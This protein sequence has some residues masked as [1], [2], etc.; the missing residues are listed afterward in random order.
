MKV[1]KSRRYLV[2][3][4]NVHRNKVLRNWKSR[5]SVDTKF[6]RAGPSLAIQ[7]VK[8]I[9]SHSL[10]KPTLALEKLRFPLRL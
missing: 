5:D 10:W 8:N 2:K 6:M 7:M 1:I 4:A 9:K 3:S